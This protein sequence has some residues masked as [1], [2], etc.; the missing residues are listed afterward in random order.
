MS[1]PQPIVYA[2]ETRLKRG[3]VRV[4]ASAALPLIP[5]GLDHDVFLLA[6]SDVLRG[7]NRGLTL[8]GPVRSADLVYQPI[9]HDPDRLP[10]G[11]VAPLDGPREQFQHALN[12]AMSIF[13]AR[14]VDRAPLQALARPQ[15]T[16][17]AALLAAEALERVGSVPYARLWNGLT[18]FQRGAVRA[19]AELGARERDR[20]RSAAEIV[21]HVVGKDGDPENFRHPLAELAGPHG[22]LC[23]VRGP[24]GGFWLSEL[25]ARTLAA[26]DRAHQ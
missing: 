11:P 25:G 23:S 8:G 10:A 13:D 4:T 24:A 19:L 18:D 20:R 3:G 1:D 17:E 22:L 5:T 15:V 21:A 12:R 7:V 6:L 9:Y 2:V 14:G 16:A 26:I